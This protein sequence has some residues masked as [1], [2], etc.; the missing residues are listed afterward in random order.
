MWFLMKKKKTKDIE[1]Y[2]EIAEKLRR[3]YLDDGLDFEKLAMFIIYNYDVKRKIKNAWKRFF[4][5]INLVSSMWW[6]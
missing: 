1:L 6:R 3:V 5:F 2:V 4:R